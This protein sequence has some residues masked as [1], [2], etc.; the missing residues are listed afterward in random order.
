MK[1]FPAIAAGVLAAVLA[2]ALLAPGA[3]GAERPPLQAGDTIYYCDRNGSMFWSPQPCEEIG[4]KQLRRGVLAEQGPDARPGTFKIVDPDAPV[5]EPAAEQTTTQA[6]APAAESA[7]AASEPET[8]ST[9]APSRDDILKQ[10]RHSLLRLLGFGLVVG[11]L[12]KWRERS[13][14]FWF[15]LGCILE[16]VLVALDV[17]PS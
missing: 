1:L 14:V 4:G 16:V 10:G 15:F 11:L 5:P 2:A 13:F 7:P 3:R 12:G 17:L 9:P 6:P 8:A